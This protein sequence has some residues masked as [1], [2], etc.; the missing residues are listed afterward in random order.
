MAAQIEVTGWLNEIKVL[1]WGTALRVSS[2]NRVKNDKGEWETASRDYYDV[3]LND[4]VSVDGIA[5]DSRV[6]VAGSFKVGKTYTKK[7][8]TTGVELRIRA[9]SIVLADSVAAPAS[10][11]AG[12]EPVSTEPF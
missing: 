7:D 1:N 5:E 3:V 10:V 12:W 11:P 2:D 8:G 6:I 9:N 4:G